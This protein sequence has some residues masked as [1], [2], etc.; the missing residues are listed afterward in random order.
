M[1][2]L[3]LGLLSDKVSIALM[4]GFKDLSLLTVFKHPFS[5]LSS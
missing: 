2:H 5:I 3:K 1:T 4:G